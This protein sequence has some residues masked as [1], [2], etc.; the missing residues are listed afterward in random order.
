M[1]R[2]I[3][4]PIEGSS[5]DAE[6]LAIARHIAHQA[7]AEVILVHIAPTFFDVKELV[8]AEQRLDEYARSLRDEGIEAHFLMEYGDPS[9]GI[10]E[11][12]R[13]QDAQ[14]IVLAPTH[15]TLLATLWHPR[16]SSG[17][18]GRATTPLFILP[19]STTPQASFELLDDPDT[20]VFL[21]LDG[22][23]NAEAAM[24]LAV[25]LAQ[26]YQRTLVLVRVAPPIF[27]LGAGVEAQHAQR[28]AQY[29]EE[30]E[31]HRYLVETRKRVAAET[32]LTVETIELVGPIAEQLT[33]L[34]A[35]RKGSVLVV[36]S[37]GHSGLKR[38]IVGSVAADVLNR[39]ST[40]LI[41]VPS[42][43]GNDEPGS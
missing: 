28:E 32:Q 19:E 41:I 4:V 5:R 35:S 26:S 18:L 14:M 21:A 34:A 6:A 31:A 27:I 25:Q 37:H 3:L 10:A 7:S 30:A 17:L 39:A 24:P 22:S 29:A 13:L 1:S 12:A 20:R 43:P 23:A 15:R 36:G 42:K 2:R 38:A 8:A 40:P 11:A 33:H 16:V 9:A